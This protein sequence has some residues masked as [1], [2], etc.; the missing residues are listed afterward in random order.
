MRV[1]KGLATKSRLLF[2]MRYL[3]EHTDDE[4]SVTMAELK[5]ELNKNGFSVTDTRTIR[6]DI[7]VIRNSGYD[8]IVTEKPGTSTRYSFGERFFEKAELRI[9]LDAISSSFSLS[10]EKSE[11][12]SR[13]LKNLAGVTDEREPWENDNFFS[14]GKSGNNQIFYVIHRILE[15]IQNDRKISFIYRYFGFADNRNPDFEQT[16]EVVSP[17][18]TVWYHDRY[19]L[20]GYSD[21]RNTME[22]YRIDWM[23]IPE[24]VDEPRTAITHV[25]SARE[26]F[27]HMGDVTEGQVWNVVLRCKQEMIGKI[28]EWF[29]EY[30]SVKKG[31]DGICDVTVPV[32][33][34]S[35]FFGWVFAYS[36]Y[37]QIIGPDRAVEAYRDMLSSALHGE[38]DL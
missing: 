38:E 3:Y 32:A 6:D 7:E 14:R 8:I 4:R 22:Q 31:E 9:M 37:I 2:L 30:M 35:R 15:G 36:K 10:P 24:P 28:G 19:Y 25:T 23:G 34:N 20:I 18:G 1:V 17:C 27:R 21:R 29:G 13:K 33:L 11:Q 16:L 5:E 12:L 26:S